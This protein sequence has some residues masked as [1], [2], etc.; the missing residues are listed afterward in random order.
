M[1]PLELDRTHP[2]C[3]ANGGGRTT[4]AVTPDDPTTATFL[5]RGL[6]AQNTCLSP[7]RTGLGLAVTNRRQM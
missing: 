5:T 4:G 7:A 1:G 2:I 6:S 3:Y